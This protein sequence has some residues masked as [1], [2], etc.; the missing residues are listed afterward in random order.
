MPYEQN[1][2]IS[3]LPLKKKNKNGHK[4]KIEQCGFTIEEVCPKDVDRMA[5]AVDLEGGTVWPGS[6][7][8][9]Q[10]CVSKIIMVILMYFAF[11]IHISKWQVSLRM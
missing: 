7:L 8:F 3:W 5:S 9:A 10:T 6:T 2:V 4:R 1:L 11:Q